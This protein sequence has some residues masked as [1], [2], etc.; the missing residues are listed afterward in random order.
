MIRFFILIVICVCVF[1]FGLYI[2]NY[3][4]RRYKIFVD[5]IKFCELYEIEVRFSKCNLKEIVTKNRELFSVEFYNMIYSYFFNNKILYSDCLKDE[6]IKL[7]VSVFSSLGQLDV[8]GE[9]ENINNHKLKI[10]Q[11]KNDIKVSC[12]KVSPLSLKLGLFGAM[13]VFIIFI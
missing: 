6:E 5:M 9:V 10:L 4:K 12:D 11:Y 3:H 2:S 13:L 1:C 8:C 7:F